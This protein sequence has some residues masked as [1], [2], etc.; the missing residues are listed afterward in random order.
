MTAHGIDLAS[1]R[2]LLVGAGGLGG[3]AGLILAR[4]GVGRIDVADDDIV[5]E[6]NLHRQLLFDESCVGRPKAPLAC[7]RLQQ[8]AKRAGHG[9]HTVAREM[10]VLPHDAQD[11]VAEYDLV[12]E[13][14]D[15]FAS[16]FLVA[17]ACALTGVPV[18][19]AGAVRWVG[20]ALASLP[21]RSACLR[22]VF[23]DVPRGRQDTCAAAGVIG[24]VVGVLG[25]LQ[26]SLA[27]R[28]LAGQTAAA[29]QLYSYRGLQ[30]QLRVC[31]VKRQEH[32]A[33]CA[34][35]ITDTDISRYLPPDC[36]A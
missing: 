10:R 13:G 11:A 23:E 27:L 30:G 15:N 9:L 17:D 31:P 2:V 14:A 29:G 4:S 20:W 36:A 8:E 35:G 6:S 18:V 3:P 19:Q 25:A 7:A 16:K 12:L 5:E 21:G 34:G 22:C 26:A 24:P 32:C 28:L 33:L 1:K